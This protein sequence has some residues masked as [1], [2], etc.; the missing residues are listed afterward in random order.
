[1]YLFHVSDSASL[2]RTIMFLNRIPVPRSVDSQI[3]EAIICPQESTV[4][5]PIVTSSGR[6]RFCI[7]HT[8]YI[9]TLQQAVERETRPASIHRAAI[10]HLCPSAGVNGLPPI[11]FSPPSIGT[12]YGWALD[13]TR[14][15]HFSQPTN[16][17]ELDYNTK[18]GF[19]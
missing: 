10:I 17:R 1:M 19:L 3:I 14:S 6:T 12:G 13:L 4:A 9:R 2:M 11:L 18:R 15:Q 7:R 16:P 8:P 5:S